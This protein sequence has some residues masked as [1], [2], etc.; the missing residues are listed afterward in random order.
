MEEERNSRRATAVGRG[1]RGG[2]VMFL[3][4]GF[5]FGGFFLGWMYARPNRIASLAESLWDDDASG[6]IDQGPSLLG[7]HLCPRHSQSPPPA[8]SSS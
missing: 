1:E 6:H 5:V 2:F 7:A 3:Y 4:C 8:P